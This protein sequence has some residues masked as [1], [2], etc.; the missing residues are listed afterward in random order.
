MTIYV[1]SWYKHPCH[2]MPWALFLFDFTHGHRNEAGSSVGHKRSYVTAWREVIHSFYQYGT[3]I[4]SFPLT[5]K[6]M[7]DAVHQPVV[8]IHYITTGL[9]QI[10]L[11]C[12]EEFSNLKSKIWFV[13]WNQCS[14]HT[15]MY[16]QVFCLAEWRIGGRGTVPV[17]ARWGGGCNRDWAG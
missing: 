5:I 4:F 14:T 6:L 13:L 7:S 10:W 2:T 16:H 17:A 12:S 9:R 11:S 3:C 8:A 15:C 1:P